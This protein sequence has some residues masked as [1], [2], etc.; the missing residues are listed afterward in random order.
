MIRTGTN[1]SF[2]ASL[3][4]LAVDKAAMQKG[5]DDMCVTTEAEIKTQRVHNAEVEKKYVEL[6]QS[7]E[8]QFTALRAEL[9]KEF[10]STKKYA[11]EV[12]TLVAGF[13]E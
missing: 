10:N 9:G 7:I 12:R 3:A 8:L 13:E 4:Q 2:A 6:T 11:V 1:E 5:Q